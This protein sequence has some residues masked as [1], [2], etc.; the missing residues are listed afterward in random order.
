MEVSTFL[1][2]AI[3]FIIII[4]MSL[5]IEDSKYR[6]AFYLVCGLGFLTILNM[7]LGIT[8]YISLRNDSG[9]QGPQGEKGPQG[10][11]GPSGECTYSSSC[12]IPDARTLILNSANKLYGIN[13]QC[14]DT[15]TLSNC[16]NNQ[17]LLDQALP[18]HNTIGM[19]EQVAYQTTMSRTDFENKL[20]VCLQD[21][22][23]CTQD[24]NF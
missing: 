4:S 2:L 19:L 22:D 24:V 15:P 12:G 21:P 20:N 14:L 10:V 16:N 11:K 7:Y 3:L 5:M 18:I 1:I 9:I 6:L 8:Y 13:T 17:A 23:N